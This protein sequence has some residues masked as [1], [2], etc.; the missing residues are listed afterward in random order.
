MSSSDH[1]M[2]GLSQGK[3]AEDDVRR[4][5]T[6]GLAGRSVPSVLLEAV[7]PNLMIPY[8][9]PSGPWVRRSPKHR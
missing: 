5:I 2:A 6:V 8:G 1:I 3:P 7:L 4:K 9:T